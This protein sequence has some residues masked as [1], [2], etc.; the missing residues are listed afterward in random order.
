MGMSDRD[1][2]ASIRFSIGKYTTLSE[3]KTAVE[4]IEKTVLLLRNR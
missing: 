1:A 3:I 2:L 4:K